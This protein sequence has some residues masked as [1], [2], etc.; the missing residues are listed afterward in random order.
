MVPKEV[1]D[2][3]IML[4]SYSYQKGAWIL[5]MIMNEVG[6]DKFMEIIQSFYLKYKYS[7]A[8]TDDFV[9]VL[10]QFVNKDWER[11]LS[12]WFYSPELPKYSIEYKYENGFIKGD[13]KQVNPGKLVFYNTVDVKIDFGDSFETIQLK[14]NSKNYQFELKTNKKPNQLIVDPANKILKAE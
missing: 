14:P 8:D 10:S 7:N 1:N 3:N 9:N 6:E 4:N 11:Y 5:N 12:P 13:L 2:P